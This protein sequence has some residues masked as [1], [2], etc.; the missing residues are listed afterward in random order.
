[1]PIWGK[2]RINSNSSILN[3]AYNPAPEYSPKLSIMGYF[4]G[5]LSI[6]KTTRKNLYLSQTK[7][8]QSMTPF[9]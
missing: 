2:N 3:E 1:M 8:G 9:G 4:K 5:T 6:Y 7:G